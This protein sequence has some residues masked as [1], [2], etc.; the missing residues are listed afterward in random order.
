MHSDQLEALLA[1]IISEILRGNMLP[2]PD[3]NQCKFPYVTVSTASVMA[4]ILDSA[5]ERLQ[6]AITRD[7]P[8]Y[9][10]VGSNQPGAGVLEP[11]VSGTL[12]AICLKLCHETRRAFLLEVLFDALEVL[13]SCIADH[14][15]MKPNGL[16]AGSFGSAF[17]R[18]AC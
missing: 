18:R 6:V 11:S 12:C 17:L 2:C 10:K 15:S 5:V 1:W 7:V 3:H 9:L 4:A 8:A 16:L 14:L 13:H